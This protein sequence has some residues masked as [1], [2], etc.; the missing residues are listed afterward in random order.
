MYFLHVNACTAPYI[1]GVIII[2]ILITI[3]ISSDIYFY[4]KV[5]RKS[6]ARV[7]T[8]MS[9]NQRENLKKFYAKKKYKPLDLRPKLTRAKRRELT[10]FEKT[11][12]TLRE[13]KWERHFPKRIYAVKM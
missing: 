11:R 1:L 10:K 7:K 2:S 5:V 13:K 3:I 4:S 9:H 8:V 6:V 12:K